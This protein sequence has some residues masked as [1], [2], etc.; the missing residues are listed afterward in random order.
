MER[1]KNKKN[2]LK[3]TFSKSTEN[4]VVVFSLWNHSKRRSS[5]GICFG[6]RTLV[7][8]A[9]KHSQRRKDKSW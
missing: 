6:K 2:Y 4:S 3:E 5:L 8:D 9:T 7:K 1:K